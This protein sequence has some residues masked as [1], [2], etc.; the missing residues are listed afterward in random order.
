MAIAQPAA[1]DLNTAIQDG[2]DRV[3]DLQHTDGLWGWPLEFSDNNSTF[4]N[5]AGPIGLG[6]ISAYADTSDSDHLDAAKDAGDALESIDNTTDEWIGNY[7]PLFMIELSNATGESKYKTHADNF[8]TAL[9]DGTYSSNNRDTSSFITEREDRRTGST[10][11]L[12]PWD[13]APLAYAAKQSGTATGSQQTALSDALK[14]GIDTLDAGKDFDVIGLAGGILG[15]K[16]IGED[17]DP[18]AGAYTSASGVDDL[19]SELVDLQNSNGSWNWRT[20]TNPSTGDED[21]QTT[22]YAMLALLEA[23]DSGQFDDEILDG[24]SYLLSQQL[25]NGGWPSY[26]GG[27]ENAEVDGEIVWALSATSEVPEPASIALLGIGGLALLRRR[28]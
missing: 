23:N 25:A 21:L 2:A 9:E 1:A 11:N 28:R 4:T 3:S 15:L 22:A 10:I 13:F 17:H 5:T 14:G 20:L 24:R 26:P 19:I 27:P 6:L 12:R 7:N 8:F 16:W 18:T